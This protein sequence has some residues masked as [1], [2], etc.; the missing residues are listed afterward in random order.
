M[1]AVKLIP[2]ILAWVGIVLVLLR[3]F[4]GRRSVVTVA[5]IS[6]FV[7]GVV[8]A[9]TLFRLFPGTIPFGIVKSALGV[10]FLFL[11]G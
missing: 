2:H 10:S 3:G 11:W 6:G 8:G 1:V 5:S 4:S 9:F 7:I